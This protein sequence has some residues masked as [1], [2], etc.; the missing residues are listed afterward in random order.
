[1]K[2]KKTI[3]SITLGAMFA[4]L[5]GIF[6]ALSIYVLQILS[7]VGLFI[8]PIFAAYYASIYKFKETL[9]FNIAVLIVCFL[10]GIADPLYCLIY[11]LPT[12][13]VGDVYGILSRLKI[14]YYTTMILQTITYS[15]TNVFALVL[16]EKFYDTQIIRFIISD[17]WTYQNLSLSIL[18]IL[19][20]AEAVVSSAFSYEQLAKVH[21][22]KEKEKQFPIY[23]YIS[24]I[25]LFILSI[26]FYFIDNNIYFLLLT[27]SIISSLGLFYEI[28]TYKHR[29]YYLIGYVVIVSSISL[30]LCYFSLFKLILLV[31][32][33]PV[34]IFSIVKILIFI[35]N[36]NKRETKEM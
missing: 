7:V 2:S 33:S 18:F 17:E 35:Y 34:F 26:I 25:A 15:I 23:G 31:F 12:L 22:Y 21:I 1:M 11:V 27:I 32:M 28:T 20:G 36:N 19:S 9:L 16:A 3:N 10:I 29:K 13:I 4:A 5:Y 14:K 8:M 6:S 30:L 24:L